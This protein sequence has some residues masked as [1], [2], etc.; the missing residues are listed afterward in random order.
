MVR[1]WNGSE[2]VLA[3][4]PLAEQ[5]DRIRA[6]V[7]IAPSRGAPAQRSRFAPRAADPS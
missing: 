2:G 3:Q 5:I 7:E 6:A 4:V 1:P